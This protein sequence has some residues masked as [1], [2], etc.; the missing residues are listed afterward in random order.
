MLAGFL[1]G[2]IADYVVCLGGF[3]GSDIALG[4][5]CAIIHMIQRCIFL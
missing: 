5:G 1:I 3:E 2:G 4:K